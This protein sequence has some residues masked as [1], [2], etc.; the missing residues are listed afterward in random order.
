MVL[1][2]HRARRKAM[3]IVVMRQALATA[4]L[5]GRGSANGNYSA[6]PDCPKGQYL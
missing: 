2:N 5:G 1:D 3:Q 6:Q 4:D